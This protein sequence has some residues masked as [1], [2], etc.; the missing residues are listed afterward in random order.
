MK[1]L[2]L[3]LLIGCRAGVVKPPLGP[4]R[5]T[6]FLTEVTSDGQRIPIAS[7]GITDVDI[8]SRIEVHVDRVRVDKIFRRA[9]HVDPTEAE[10][11]RVRLA[12][13]G[14]LT[15]QQKA[16]IDRFTGLV[17]RRK[18]EGSVAT[19]SPELTTAV[20]KLSG[21]RLSVNKAIEAYAKKVGQSPGDYF[22]GSGLQGTFTA[23]DAERRRVF[24]EAAKLAEPSRGL[25]WRMQAV[26]AKTGPI[27]LDNY[28]T[29]PDGPFGLIDKLTPQTTPKELAAQLEEARQLAKDLQDLSHAKQTALKM[30]S[31]AVKE[32]FDSL[33]HA[34]HDDADA[35]EAIIKAIP[36]KALRIKEVAD[37]RK[38]LAAVAETIR[39]LRTACNSLI[40]AAR[41]GALEGVTSEQRASCLRA[42]AETGPKLI[43]QIRNADGALQAFAALV[44]KNPGRLGTLLQP[45]KEL[46]P[47]LDT[48]KLLEGWAESVAQGWDQLTGLLNLGSQVASAPVWTAEQQIDLSL[49]EIVDTAIDLRRTRRREGDLLHF[50]PLVVKG[51]GSAA[52][53]GAT[54]DFRVV[55]MGLYLDVSAGVSFVDKRDDAWGPF[56]AAPGIAAAVHYH[57]RSRSAS[58]RFMNTLRP[59]IGIHFLNPDLD[60]TKVDETGAVTHEDAAFEL[61]VGGSLLLFGDLLQVGAGYDLQAKASYWY[62]GFGLDTLAR[63]GV[64][65]SLGS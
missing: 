56:S 46:V 63:L 10:A 51:D 65:F 7:G 54:S 42:T 2:A 59:G 39:E 25:R 12:E 13:L 49:E 19:L 33:L 41:S 18:A 37:L 1:A 30:M 23:L 24:L 61:G 3:C 55:R 53:V 31:T 11:I 43:A 26:F 57:F 48:V 58:A 5:E 6:V 60:A 29:Y 14:K 52:I 36:A 47:R 8:N 32:L 15:R 62:L 28:D 44:E 27:H 50:R 9:T 4:L 17:A 16:M 22:A 64:R 38:H 20:E 34:M 40:D 35:V 45:L 21:E